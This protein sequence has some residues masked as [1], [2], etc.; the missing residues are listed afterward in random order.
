MSTTIKKKKTALNGVVKKKETS[1]KVITPM[2]LLKKFK[3]KPLFTIAKEDEELVYG[4]N[5][6]IKLMQEK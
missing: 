6:M 1:K 3:K 2:D 4:S 5:M